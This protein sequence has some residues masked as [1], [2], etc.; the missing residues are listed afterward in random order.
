[1]KFF[2]QRIKP[3]NPVVDLRFERHDTVDFLGFEF[4]RLEIHSALPRVGMGWLSN[5][6]AKAESVVFNRPTI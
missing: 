3:P 5:A 1:V 6:W 2:E 4:E